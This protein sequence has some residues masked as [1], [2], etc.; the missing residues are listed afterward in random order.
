M[1]GSARDAPKHTQ[2][3]KPKLRLWQRLRQRQRLRLRLRAA[4]NWSNG[5][6]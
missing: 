2:K 3:L 1:E 6:L 5:A 4:L